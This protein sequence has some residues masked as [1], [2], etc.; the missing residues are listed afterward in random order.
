MDDGLGGAPRPLLLVQTERPGNIE[1]TRNFYDNIIQRGVEFD[2]IGL[3]YYPW[4]HGSLLEVRDCLAFIAERY[5]K[6][7]ILVEVAYNW[8]PAEYR[9]M[10]PPFPETP[11]GQREFWEEVN[12]LVLEIPNGLGKGVFWWEP[13]VAGRGGISS[14]GMFD[15]EGNALPVVSVFDKFTRGKVPTKP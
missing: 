9:K 11:E 13:A 2:I 8:R 15:A 7:I 4:W 6:D 3:S 14:R 5:K 1:V 10:P 12:R